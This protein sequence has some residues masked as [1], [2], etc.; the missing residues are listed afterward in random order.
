MIH[1][2]SDDLVPYGNSQVAFNNFSTAG[3]KSHV[4]RGPGVELVEE[5][6]LINVSTDPVKTVHFA[7]AFPEL[8]RG[9]QWIESFR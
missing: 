8:S 9:W 6:V 1:H 3:G 5:T 4:P 2:R 7:S